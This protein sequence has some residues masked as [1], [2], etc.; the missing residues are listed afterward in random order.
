MEALYNNDL[1]KCKL[2]ALAFNLKYEVTRG[3]NTFISHKPN[4]LLKK[5]TANCP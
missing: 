3:S 2:E 5:A 4:E 1:E